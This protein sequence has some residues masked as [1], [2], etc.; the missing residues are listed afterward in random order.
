MNVFGLDAILLLLFSVPVI[1]QY[2]ILPIV[3]TPYWLFTILFLIL[4]S[5]ILVSTYPSLIA[6]SSVREKTKTLLFWSALLIV[7]VGSMATAII[8]RGRTAPGANYGVHDIILQLESAL[9]Y[10]SLGKNPY[11]ET[12]FG[13]EME[14]WNYTELGATVV[15]PALYHFVMPPWYLLFSTV[16]YK[17]SNHFFGFFD[18]RMP[19]LFTIM[20]TSIVMSL[21]FKSHVL[22]RLAI[23]VTTISP[24]IIGYTIEGRSD[25]FALFWL[26][27]SLFLLEKRKFIISTLIFGLAL[28]SK[29]T[30]WFAVPFYIAFMMWSIPKKSGY[31]TYLGFGIIILIVSILVIPFLFWDGK[32]FL[33]S[34]VFYLIGNTT[35]AYPI[36]GYGFS[37]LLYSLGLIKDIH[38]YYPFGIWQLTIGTPV[39]IA[40]IWFIKRK[41]VMSRWLMGFAI[42]LLVIWYLSRYFNNSHVA[43]ISTIFAIAQ[44]KRW[45]EERI[46]EN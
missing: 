43:Y 20:G 12:Y 18:G 36:S 26:I 3:G 8:D 39:F 30:N 1:F 13:T 4:F 27:T 16:F 32:A 5:N 22:G 6:N 45:D 44:L 9:R 42:T 24:A 23:L 7:L 38:G 21:W 29:Q 17:V 28:M 34:V 33:E 31:L 10:L 2:R 19:L 40:S 15:N 37:M 35:F 11:K 41:P 46:H 14:K 25:G